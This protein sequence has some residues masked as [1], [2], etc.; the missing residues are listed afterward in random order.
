MFFAGTAVLMLGGR[1]MRGRR[2]TRVAF[3]AASALRDDE[4]IAGLG[5]IVQHL[6]GFPVVDDGADRDGNVD[7][8]A[9]AALSDCCLRRDVRARLYVRD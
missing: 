1:L 6:A 4:T 2:E 7:G 5:E 9:F 3:A 8:L